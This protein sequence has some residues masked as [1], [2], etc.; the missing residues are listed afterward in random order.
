MSHGLV[1]GKLGD[2]GELRGEV[3]GPDLRD[4]VHLGAESLSLS[5]GHHEVPH[6]AGVSDRD[7]R[8]EFNASGDA[9]IIYTWE[10]GHDH[11]Y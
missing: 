11:T 7:I 8:H 3:V 1:G 9:D 2:G 5:R 10:K 6:L 4:E